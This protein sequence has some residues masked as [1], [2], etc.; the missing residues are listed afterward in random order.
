MT[1]LDCKN[2]KLNT[3]KWACD[4]T[5]AFRPGGWHVLIGASGAGK[6]T[7]LHLLTG[8]VTPQFGEIK[9]AGKSIGHLPPHQRNLSFMSQSN[10]LF[11][12]ITIL[13]NLLLALHDSPAPKEEKEFRA[14][15][16][17]DRLSLDQ[18]LLNRP[19]AKLSGG[20][21]SR[22]NLART[23]LRPCTWLLLDEPFSA[24]DRWTRLSILKWLQDWQKQTG[25]GIILVSHDLDDIFTVASDVHVVANGSILESATLQDSLVRPRYAA[26]GRMLRAGIV[27]GTPSGSA[28]VNSQHLSTPSALMAAKPAHLHTIALKSAQ[29]TRMGSTMRII[30]LGSQCDLVL[31]WDDLFDGT[32]WYDPSNAVALMG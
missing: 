27:V 7:L 32:L 23:L 30:D 18:E 5:A 6:S 2:L 14:R 24:V 31:P 21:L 17:A 29:I 10:S 15:E 13:Q 16:M 1:Q 3:E 4:Y 11:P 20:Q 22:C 8:V 12:S 9:I 26:T 25:A 19:A 28:F